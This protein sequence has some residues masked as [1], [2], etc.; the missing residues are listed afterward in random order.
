M[1]KLIHHVSVGVIPQIQ[2]WFSIQKPIKEI[3]YIN[4]LKRKDH[5][6]KSTD[7]ERHLTKSN[8][9]F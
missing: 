2:D 9:D 4:K 8:I 7:A 6:T 3:H 5:M 1:K